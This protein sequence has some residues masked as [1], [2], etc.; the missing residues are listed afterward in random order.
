MAQQVAAHVL[1]LKSSSIGDPPKRLALAPRLPHD[2][3][4]RCRQ[5]RHHA[6]PGLHDHASSILMVRWWVETATF[7][8]R[9]DARRD[10]PK[11]HVA[12]LVS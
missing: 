2:L 9:L 7:S 8:V 5:R 11:E 6:H 10:T 1:F 3:L 4:H 12:E